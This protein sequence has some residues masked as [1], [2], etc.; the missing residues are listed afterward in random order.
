NNTA[1]TTLNLTWSI[2]IISVSTKIKKGRSKINP[3]DLA[4]HHPS[5]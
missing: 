1:S 4:L 3:I 2:S 5:G